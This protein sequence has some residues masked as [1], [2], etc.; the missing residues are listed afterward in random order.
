MA[1]EQIDRE[2]AAALKQSLRRFR[3]G[4]GLTQEQLAERAGI[5]WKYYQA[6]EN[7]KGNSAKDSVANPS[8]Q[9]IR[10]LAGAYGVSVPDLM[11]D[12]FNDDERA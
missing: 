2:T 10:K 5:D 7:G 4:T 1:T 11:W 3:E 12:V 6:L 9:I 8:L